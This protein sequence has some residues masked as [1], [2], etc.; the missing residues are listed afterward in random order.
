[1]TTPNSSS[2]T[3]GV[4]K[5]LPQ[6]LSVAQILQQSRQATLT[7]PAT[8]AGNPTAPT[9]ASGATV[10]GTVRPA[11][12]RP[13]PS[14]GIGS[15]TATTGA[16][17]SVDGPEFGTV[18]PIGP[19]VV[20]LLSLAYR[21]DVPAMLIGPHGI[22]KSEITAAAAKSLNISCIARDLS[23]M[24]PPDLIGLPR[25]GGNATTFVPPEFLPREPE[26]Q[27]FLVFEELNRAPR[28]MQATCLELLTSRRLNDYVL[29][30]GILPVACLNPRSSG[31]HVDLLDA[32]LMSRFVKIEVRAAV[33]P[34]IAWARDHG[35]HPAIIQYVESVPG[36]LDEAAGGVNPRSWSYASKMLKAAGDAGFAGSSD[37][38]VLGLTGLLGPVHTTALVRL[39]LGTETALRPAD[40]LANWPVCRS[41]MRRWLEHG[42]LDLLAGSMRAVLQWLRSDAVADQ[43]RGDDV[44]T[45]ILSDFFEALPG[46]LAE[47]GRSCLREL[48][49]LFLLPH[50]LRMPK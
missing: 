12:R 13:R 25:L 23:L 19:A 5:G 40:V 28:H 6:K 15:A 35:V 37:T 29:P 31:Y 22:G 38:L 42:R 36:S 9:P 24:E 26:A 10:P 50:T 4:P 20:E 47:Q 43:V 17:S 41:T 16:V 33:E 27:G 7:A 32:A 44:K 49:H 11:R 39:I 8:A 3:P 2:T 45:T 18:A 48:G 30:P 34:W 1:M 14:S 46:D 21:A